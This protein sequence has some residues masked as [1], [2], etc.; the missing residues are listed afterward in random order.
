MSS[1]RNK[2]A[3]LVHALR[4]VLAIEEE[5]GFSDKAVAGGLDRFLVT[6]RSASATHPALKALSDHGLLSI[7]YGD[8]NLSQRQ[9]WAKEIFRVLG[10]APPTRK[11]TEKR[12]LSASNPDAAGLEAKSVNLDDP[13]TTLPGVSSTTASRLANI[14]LNTIRDLVMHLPS[15]HLDY[16]NRRTISELK[17]NEDQTIVC[18]LWEA[19][20]IRLGRGGRLRATEAVVGDETGNLRIVWFGQPWVARSLKSASDRAGGSSGP[21]LLSLSGK[22]VEFNGRR[23]MDSPEWEPLDEPESR[24]LVH[25]GRLVPVY[26]TTEKVL[27]RTMRRHVRTALNSISVDGRLLIEDPLPQETLGRLNLMGLDKAIEQSHYP[28]SLEQREEAR[29]RLAFDE[30]LTLQLVMAGQRGV[31]EVQQSGIILPSRPPLVDSFLK[32]LPFQLTNGQ[33]AAIEDAAMDISSGIKPMS[34][35]LQGDVGSG[36]TIVALALLLNAVAGAYQGAL[37]APTEVLA[38]QHF[39]NIRRI[40][41]DLSDFKE[42][43]SWFSFKLDGHP[44]PITFGLLTG[45]T[46]ASARQEQARRSQE[47]ELDILIGTHAVI[48]DD[49]DLPNLA[50]AVVDEQH[51]FGV[52]QRAALRNKGKDPHLLLMSATPIPRTLTLTLYGDLDVSSMPELPSGRKEIVTRIVPADRRED[53]EQFLVREAAMGRRSFIVC[54]LIDESEAISARAATSE[55]ERLKKTSLATLNVGLLHGR[56]PMREK[57]RIMDAFRG[58]DLDVLVST[59][60]IEVGIDVPEATVMLIEGADRFGLA[61]LHQLRGRVG[62]GPEQSYCFL[63]TD[64]ASDDAFKRLNALAATNNGFDIAEADLQ[65]RGS[66]DVFGTRQSGLQ[67]LRIAR[68]T[69]RKLIEESRS[70]ARALMDNDPELS[71]HPTLLSAV[72]RFT[73]TVVDDVS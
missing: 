32:S 21:S 62:R 18:T 58:G 6:L 53:A 65:L 26:G 67:A 54:P 63:L 15:R 46:T 70:E 64:S 61:Q 25:T 73:R 55:Y 12:P 13:T 44:I 52:L 16:S 22:V 51:R 40:A 5:N 10:E 66:G 57:Q 4:Q 14:S 3:A 29:K 8:V 2:A 69:D 50:L 72:E 35:L 23:Q 20:E 36:K 33:R 42:G 17:L 48:Q 27:A 7:S 31:Q 39:L 19:R 71:N 9:R 24:N 37:M 49:I 11:P 60:V 59:P 68:I 30:L 47:G 38:E 45:G 56:M 41:Y 43:P 34:R 28:D 1:L